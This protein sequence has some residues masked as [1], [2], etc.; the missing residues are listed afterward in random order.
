MNNV[1]RI[2]FLR[3]LLEE[4]RHFIVCRSFEMAVFQAGFNGFK[5]DMAAFEKSNTGELVART[6]NEQMQRHGI[7]LVV[8]LDREDPNDPT[9]IGF[10]LCFGMIVVKDEK[11]LEGLVEYL[12]RRRREDAATWMFRP[13]SVLP[14]AVLC[15]SGLIRVDEEQEL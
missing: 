1:T 14:D 9:F 12:M 5:L 3:N 6:A 10:S 7:P 13:L 11:P 8:S 15:P 2:A 4:G